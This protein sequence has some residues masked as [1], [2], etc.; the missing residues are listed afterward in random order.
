[1]ENITAV[2][3]YEK[4]FSQVSGQEK[5]VFKALKAVNIIVAGRTGVGKSTLINAVFGEEVAKAG[6]GKPVTQD[7]TWYQAKAGILRIL[8]TKGLEAKAFA[9]TLAT[10]KAQIESARA[11]SDVNEQLHVAWL[12]IDE[13]STRVQDA[14]IDVIRLLNEHQIPAIVVLTKHGMNP[15]FSNQVSEI[16]KQEGALVTGV[17]PVAAISTN[18]AFPVR[19]LNE[20]VSQTLTVLPDGAKNA[21]R[22]AQKVNARLKESAAEKLVYKASTAAAGVAVSPVPF[23]DAIG[24]IPIQ[25]G[26]TLAISRVFGVQLEENSL[27]PLAAGVFSSIGLSIFGRWAAGSLIKLIPGGGTILGGTVSA[28]I[29]GGLTYSLGMT[30]VKFLSSFYERQGRPPEVSEVTELFPAYFKGNKVEAD[31]PA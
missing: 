2:L 1:M 29:A 14:E 31:Q 17:I 10:L 12:C 26:M 16:F 6:T 9:E 7:A 19:G 22:A 27:M 23:S 28:S 8:D 15:G 20:L 25:V 13:P 11:A 3:D 24:I 5:E 21:F 18:P 4:L 30:Y